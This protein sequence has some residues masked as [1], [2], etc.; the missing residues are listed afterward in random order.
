MGAIKDRMRSD[1]RLRGY[2]DSTVS[3]YLRCARK[4]V[5]HYMVSPEQLG[6][7]EIRA[8][9]VHLAEEKRCSL[10]VQKM[11][12][13]GI[14]FLYGV[15]LGRPEDVADICWPKVPLKLTVVLSGSEVERLL[16]ALDSDKLRAAVTAVYASG[17]RVGEVC[18][19]Q[20]GDIDSRR[21]LILVRQGKGRKDRYVML[22]KRLLEVLRDYWRA[23]RPA[24]S[25]M[26]PGSGRSGHI[27]RS[28]V[29][30]AAKRAAKKAGI[31][32]LV[33]PTVLRHCFAT[34]LLEAGADIREIQLLL[35]HSSIQTTS[36]YLR[37]SRRHIASLTS[38]LDLLGTEQG[39]V[40]G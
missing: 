14:K 8:F 29:Q 38:P 32:K 23:A 36:R 6:N 13:A 1:L 31:S 24:G 17:L 18:R 4:F 26:F 12:V 34:H 9:V 22:S 28:T 27:V 5:K 7:K 19:L 33:T 15:T 20:V 35:G 40:L 16:A 2:S 21:M 3:E 10:E 39:A 30:R 37:V 11:H 25:Y